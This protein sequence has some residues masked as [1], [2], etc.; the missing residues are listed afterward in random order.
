MKNA[1]DVK[2]G[3]METPLSRILP[4]LVVDGSLWQVGSR[5][6]ACHCRLGNC[7]RNT[8]TKNSKRP[9]IRII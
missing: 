2:W 1:I 5:D 4:S 3:E 8:C 7:T 9:H 6:S